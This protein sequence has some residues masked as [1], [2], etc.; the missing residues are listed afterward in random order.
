MRFRTKGFTSLLLALSFSIVVI[1]GLALYVSPKGRVANWT[2]W[3]LVGLDKHQ[4]GALHINICLLFLAGA[5]L[6]LFFNWKVFLAY[7]KNRTTGLNLKLEM[8]VASLVTA[9]VVV[10]TWADAPPFTV[11]V[12]V[13]DQ[14]KD[15]WEAAAPQGPAPHA[16]EFTLVKFAAQLGL[17]VDQVAAALRTEGYDISDNTATVADLARQKG[18]PPS[19]V[20]GDLRKH[21]PDELKSGRGPG[22]GMGMGMG[23]GRGRGQGRGDH[24]PPADAGQADDGSRESAQGERLAD[25]RQDH[26]GWG[27]GRGR[28]EGPGR[29]AGRGQGWGRGLEAGQG[30]G[31]GAGQGRGPG[32]GASG[33]GEGSASSAE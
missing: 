31:P 18:T 7:I 10:G 3:T 6:H 14:L 23:M 17:E 32:G 5:A 12:A 25:D 28:G 27:P 16:E 2:G 13:S 11:P 21:F 4:W 30:R 20:F 19:G 26:P 1:S 33:S 22:M 9:V 29:G 8:A 24:G 15:Y